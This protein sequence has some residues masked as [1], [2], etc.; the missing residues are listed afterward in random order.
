MAKS[1]KRI[2]TMIHGERKM[3]LT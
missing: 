3:V 1:I 2:D